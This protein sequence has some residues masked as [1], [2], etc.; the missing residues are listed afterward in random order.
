[1]RDLESKERVN[2]RDNN[3]P[4]FVHVLS[5]FQSSRDALETRNSDFERGEGVVK[6]RNILST[7]LTCF[8]S[9]SVG[10]DIVKGSKE[11]YL[12]PPTP[13]NQTQPQ[14]RSKPRRFLPLVLISLSLVSLYYQFGPTPPQ[15]ALKL[16]DLPGHSLM[17]Y[18]T[19]FGST[20]SKR[21]TLPLS[22]TSESTEKKHEDIYSKFL[23]VPSAESAKRI[24]KS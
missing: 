17:G 24:S 18:L 20:D 8:T 14:P 3:V 2:T 7:F 16:R 6:S 12:P 15:H 5:S 4:L 13:H 10:M 9:L 23:S 1:M 19:Q 21:G 11:S 22:S